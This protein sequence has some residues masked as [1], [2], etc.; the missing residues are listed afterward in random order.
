[1]IS[2]VFYFYK[3]AA[4]GIKEKEREYSVSEK[5]S[6]EMNLCSAPLTLES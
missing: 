2:L 1:M 6:S 4:I 5:I 3:Q